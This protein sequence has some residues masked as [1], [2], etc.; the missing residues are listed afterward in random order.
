MDGLRTVPRESSMNLTD[1]ERATL[2]HVERLGAALS[3]VGVCLIF[4]TYGF[5]PRVRTVPNTFIFFASIANVGASIACLIGY[6]GILAGDSSAL[7]QGQAFLLEIV[8]YVAVGY[9]VFHHRNQLRNLT[10]SNQARDAYCAERKESEKEQQSYGTVTTE[11]RVTAESSGSPTPPSTPAGSIAPVLN[12]PSTAAANAPW[13]QPHDDDN[14]DVNAHPTAFTTRGRG[15]SRGHTHSTTTHA[16]INPH[17]PTPF[18]TTLTI[19]SSH[20]PKPPKRPHTSL[21]TRL[22]RTWRKFQRKL[23]TLDP[24]KLAYL[25]TSFVFALSI[26]VTWTPSSINRVYSLAYPTRTSYGL[27]LASAVVLPLQGLWN[28]TIFAAASWHILREEWL[29]ARRRGRGCGGFWCAGVRGGARRLSSGAG[30]HVGGLGGGGGGVG[31]GGYEERGGQVALSLSGQGF[32]SR[33]GGLPEGRELT[34]MPRVAN[35][36]KRRR[37]ILPREGPYT[38]EMDDQLLGAFQCR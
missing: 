8:I 3:L 11:V 22:A 35:G 20:P 24:I 23:A 16:G 18:T 19:S 28:A 4:I 17:H 5:F 6:S 7:C 14:Y 33:D 26:L 12:R 2:Q 36:R 25:R 1:E 37:W 30:G 9:H 13:G 15:S 31:G 34:T 10:L 27:N 38:Q 29:E 32:R 21:P